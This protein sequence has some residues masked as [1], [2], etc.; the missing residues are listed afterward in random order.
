MRVSLL[1][2]R[3][4]V[5]LGASLIPGRL[6]YG[7][8]YF[9]EFMR[10]RTLP[11]AIDCVAAAIAFHTMFRGD[12]WSEDRGTA[13]ILA[14]S[15]QADERDLLRFHQ[16]IDS[17]YRQ[18]IRPYGTLFPDSLHF[19]QLAPLE[20][21][22]YTRIR[23]G[24]R[25]VE[26]GVST[27]KLAVGLRSLLGEEGVQL[28]LGHTATRIERSDRGGGLAVQYERLSGGAGRIEA[29]V[30]VQAAGI[31]GPSLDAQ[32]GFFDKWHLQLKGAA[33]FPLTRD[34]I[35]LP[36]TYLV[37]GGSF[38]FHR[39]G[40]SSLPSNGMIVS[41]GRDAKEIAAH[42]LSRETGTVI[43]EDWQQWLRDLV[44]ATVWL[45]RARRA[46]QIGATNIPSLSSCEPVGF[47]VRGILSHD[48][49]R[50]RRSHVNIYHE[51]RGY[52]ATACVKLSSAAL[53]AVD[54]ANRVQHFLD[55]R[56][57]R[58]PIPAY[59][60]DELRFT[61]RPDPEKVRKYAVAH[62]LTPELVPAALS[63]E[64]W[65]PWEAVDPG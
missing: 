25:T 30:V 28:L 24:V 13:F 48:S 42:T 21:A 31:F 39:R 37:D 18:R 19:R 45:E 33:V 12:Y 9:K 10:T 54:L 57:F 49:Q 2:A 63:Q 27:A 56:P 5:F 38:N 58:T 22:Y 51:D 43:P 35:D 16:A 20:R 14:D 40:P 53:L 60:P 55:P 36:T 50:H 62:G 52:F 4:D 41:A 1:E 11:S 59:V 23:G 44:P 61:I 46:V 7:G 29:D 15:S 3:N 34:S 8:M 32:V 17:E 64:R 26:P 65:P 47:I 6:H